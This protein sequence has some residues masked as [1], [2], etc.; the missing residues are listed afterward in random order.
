MIK[1]LRAKLI[2]ACMFS[3]AVVLL[4]ILGGVNLMSYQKVV[5]DADTVL[6]LL[7]AN[8]GTFP[9]P[10]VPQEEKDEG[11][12]APLGVPGGKPGLF[13]QRIMSPETPYESRFFSVLLGEDGQVLETNTL[14]IAAVDAEQ[15]ADYAQKAAAS[16]RTSGFLDDF[17][18]LVQ[19]ESGGVRLI[20][21]D[22]GRSLSSFRTTLL[23][24]VSLAVLGLAA[25][26]FL[27][28][29]LSR[30]IVRPVAESYEKQRQFITDAG[31][32]LKTPMTIISADAD[33]AE[34]ECGENQWL[35]DIRRQAQRLTALT[36]DLIYLSRMEEEQPKL[37]YIDFPI[38]DVVE[39]MAQSF[40]APARSQDKE[41]QVQ[42]QPML[43][44]Q[45]D[46]KG[47]RQLVSILLDNA[48]KY[49]P[50][51]GQLVLRLEKQGRNLLLTVSNTCAQPMEQDKLPHLF[52]RFYRTDQSRNSQSGGYGLG[53]SIAKSIVSA[54]KGKIRAESPDG[55][56]LRIQVTLA[57]G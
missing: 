34:M 56:T 23:A 53:L 2:L 3:L 44:F 7:A 18:F 5:S 24:S 25:V 46:E 12:F 22:C 49:S 50:C 14:Q 17:R 33:L 40:A 26:L 1:K 8:N 57:A 41:L 10:R 27:L 20:F 39:E 36:N 54:H 32:E 47:I 51:G 37:Q 15:A 21:L 19:N 55:T 6:S 4:V 9:K 16:G 30:R 29:I 42:V 35:T 31:H 38:S 52:D 13:D 43:S 45:G 11:S 28:L 48:L